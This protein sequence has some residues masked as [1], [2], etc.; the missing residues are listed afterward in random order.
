MTADFL[1]P[2]I[3]V[4]AIVTSLS[5]FYFDYTR[6][7]DAGN[8]EKV[9]TLTFKRLIAQ[10]KY[11]KQV[12]WEEIQT[13]TPVFNNDSIR[14]AEESDAVIRLN[15]GTEIKLAENSLIVLSFFKEEFD[16]QFKK[17]EVLA[18]RDNVTDPNVKKLNISS[19]DTKVS[20]TKGDLSLSGDGNDLNIS[21]AKGNANISAAGVNRE[22]G[23]NQLAI[24]GGDK[25]DLVELN[26]KLISPAHHK[27]YPTGIRS[28]KIDF[29][30]ES[31]GKNVD[32][33]FEVSGNRKFNSFVT[34]KPVKGTKNSLD[35][36]TGN[37]YWRL[38]GVNRKTKKTSYSESRRFSI[39]TEKPV[40]LIAPRN[41]ATISYKSEIPPVNFKWIKSLIASSY[42]LVVADDPEMKN[43]IKNIN[44]TGTRLAVPD[45][46]KGVYYWRVDSKTRFGEEEFTS[47][48]KINKMIITQNVQVEPPV[49]VFPPD[50]RNINQ[51]VLA[52]KK[53]TFTWR[54][55]PEIRKNIFA[56]SRDNEFK[57]V[58]FS[59]ES[60]NNFNSFQKELP[61]GNYFW[62]VTGYAKG[63]DKPVHSLTRRFS[64]T[65]PDKLRL[66]NPIQNFLAVPVRENSLPNVLF[67]WNRSGLQGKYNLQISNDA[68]FSSI[69]RQ[70]KSESLS[71][72][73]T[74]FDPGRYYWRVEFYD[75]EDVKLM[76]SETRIISV[77][78]SLRK[79]EVIQPGE[80][81]DVD[82]SSNDTLSLQWKGI[83][84]ADYYK[85]GLYREQGGRTYNLV[86]TT[87]RDTGF[88][89]RDFK[90]LEEGKF[91]WTLQAMDL[92]NNRKNGTGKVIRRSPVAKN[93]F[94]IVLK[95]KNTE[96][97]KKIKL[98]EILIL[99]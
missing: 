17:G 35:L 43:I 3:G 26:L 80:G 1:V 87:V 37:Y 10:R 7:V 91:F 4:T 42:N 5:L 44:M 74:N 75:E 76:T 64:I 25:L 90:K 82:M 59:S 86:N 84:D 12:V 32:L 65:K 49:L 79:P 58:L 8:L 61:L 31:V 38:R 60:E 78:G 66:I 95:N 57:S 88:V 13:N 63:D 36:A 39:V 69:Y 29:S 67:T 72:T 23:E 85:L 2:F 18:N 47:A 24:L 93:Y 14:T 62:R 6:K 48:S 92:D 46:G 68:G 51:L 94:N 20:L 28:R 53:I 71:L 77:M 16:I 45:L 19:A 41:N 27:Y 81:N 89:F 15:D 97:A 54:K 70:E 52:R 9:G 99:K 33:F 96:D 55:N 30:W 40:I 56:I 34:Q 22:L 73:V 21:V 98:P 50:N 11:G 83:A